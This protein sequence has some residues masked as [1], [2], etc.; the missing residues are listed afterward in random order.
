MIS[1]LVPHLDNILSFT[2]LVFSG[3]LFLTTIRLVRGTVH[4]Q[5]IRFFKSLLAIYPSCFLAIPVT[6]IGILLIIP[7][8]V[9]GEILFKIPAKN[10][11]LTTG[12]INSLI[13]LLPGVSI[14]IADHFE[15][16]RGI[17]SFKD[18]KESPTPKFR[19]HDI[20]QAILDECYQFGLS[21]PDFS[22]LIN[23]CRSLYLK[24]AN[25][26]INNHHKIKIPGEYN[27]I[28]FV[29]IIFFIFSLYWTVT[30]YVSEDESKSIES[31]GILY[32]SIGFIFLNRLNNLRVVKLTY[33]LKELHK[34]ALEEKSKNRVLEEQ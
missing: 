34:L 28:F 23:H 26:T 21:N 12:F 7:L 3:V 22:S 10:E 25:L 32:A 33:Y 14:Y 29:L 30:D 18:F 2:L 27:F 9:F 16:K 15:K 13:I 4:D 31:F 5:F 20:F 24:K 17:F 1:I 8:S 6:V 19:Q 11:I